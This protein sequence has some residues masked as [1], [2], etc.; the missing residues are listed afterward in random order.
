NGTGKSS[1]LQ[2]FASLNAGNSRRISASRQMWFQSS[3]IEFSPAQKVSYEQQA[4]N[5]DSS[6]QS[7]WMEQNAQLRSG[8]TLYDLIDAENVDARAIATALRAGR[9]EEAEA[10]AQQVAPI[11][12]IN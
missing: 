8:L 9:R 4:R 2:R 12:K 6:V 1:L 5:W 10:L 3:A 11:A 7:R